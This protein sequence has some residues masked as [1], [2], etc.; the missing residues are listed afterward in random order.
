ML[1]EKGIGRPST[2]A[3]ILTTI[4][5]R[6][7]VVKQEGKFSPTELGFVINDVLVASFADIFDINTPLEWKKTRRDEEGKIGWTQ[8]LRTSTASLRRPEDGWR[9]HGVIREPEPTD[10][11]CEK[12]GSRWSFGGDVTEGSWLFGFPNARTPARSHGRWRR[13]R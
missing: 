7:Y 4:Q 12:C 11:K 2:Y 3:T 1:E 9:A 6:E 10:E 8:A 13:Q 5:D